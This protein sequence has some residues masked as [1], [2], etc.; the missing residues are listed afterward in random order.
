MNAWE[1]AS[2]GEL[3]RKTMGKAGETMADT[4]ACLPVGLDFEAKF[5]D[6]FGSAKGV[7]FLLWTAKRVYFPVVYD[8]AEW[9]ES[10]PRNPDFNEKPR[11]FGG[12]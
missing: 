3:I 7:P 2:W 11:H 5:D 6:G 9:V 1:K 12:Q 8:G 10:V 4:V